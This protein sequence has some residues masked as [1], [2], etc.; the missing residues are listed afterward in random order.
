MKNRPRKLRWHM[1]S[2]L[3]ITTVL[4]WLGFVL[5]AYNSR[6]NELEDAVGNTFQS[7]RSTLQTNVLS[8]YQENRANGLGE[9][10]DH[11]LMSSLSNQSM[12]GI[13]FMNGGTA[14][15]VR[16]GENLVR[17]QI[18]WGLGYEAEDDQA[19]YLYFDQGLDDEGQ[20]EFARWMID[21]RSGWAYAIYPLEGESGRNGE[22]VHTRI[23]V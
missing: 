12:N 23:Q 14:L 16:A 6:L 21:H 11:I 20:L 1:A 4:L 22:A 19:W 8:A 18:T 9:R 2:A 13:E 5:L 3:I 15:A 17:S 7:T 10:A